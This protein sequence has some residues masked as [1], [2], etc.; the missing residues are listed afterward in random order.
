MELIGDLPARPLDPAACFNQHGDPSDDGVSATSFRGPVAVVLPAGGCGE[1][2]GL[3][4]PKQFCKLLDRPLISYTIHAFERIKWI[5]AVIVVVA[6]QHVE[7]MKSIIQKYNHEKTQWCVGGLTRH[8]S[9]F[10][11]LS[12]FVDDKFMECHL[13][14][15]KVV[16]IHDAVRPFVNED[17][18]LKIAT[19]AND[20]GAAGAIRPLVSTVIATNSEHFLDHSLERSKYRAS[21]MPQAFLFDTIYKAYQKCTE[22]DFE[23]GTEC[24]HLVLS[25]CNTQA[26]LIEGPPT[27]WKVTYKQ[28]LFAAESLIKETLSQNVYVITDVDQEALQL[29]HCLKKMLMTQHMDVEVIS[30]E[31]GKKKLCIPHVSSQESYNIIIIGNTDLQE[32]QEVIDVIANSSMTLL[33]P[34]VLI[35]VYISLPES[36]PFSKK[37]DEP[38]AI[39]RLAKE[40]KHR[41]ILVYGLLVNYTK[42]SEEL[43]ESLENMCF[44]SKSLMKDRNSALTGQLLVV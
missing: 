4:T 33:Y 16:I 36:T 14:K 44:I 6:E 39:R 30:A 23:Y 43:N 28:D 32:K 5:E 3:S 10:N 15:P 22:Y 25:Y 19:A 9:I 20:H 11:G 41:N 40:A 35:L 12:V 1:R 21:E 38:S 8:R 2:M 37:L 42:D 26:K 18:L 34:M 7:L 29:G 24:L 13:T 31:Y 17:I 27:L